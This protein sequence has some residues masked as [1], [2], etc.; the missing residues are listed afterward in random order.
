MQGE[1]FSQKELSNNEL[2]NN[3]GRFQWLSMPN[4]QRSDEGDDEGGLNLGQ[5]VSTLRR[6]IPV[7]LGVTTVVT[8]A[9][10]LKAMTSTPTYQSSF[11]I[12]TKPVTIESQVISS[13]PQTL[14]NKEQQQAGSEKG[15]DPTKL[16]LLQ[17]P[18]LLSPIVKQLQEK[19]PEITYDDIAGDLKITAPPTSEILS[20]TFQDKNAEKVKDVLKLTQDSYINYS[21][22]ERLA[23]VNQGIEFVNAQLPLLQERV[24]KIQDKLQTF[25]QEFNLID[26]E[27]TSKELSGQTTTV[28]Q[29]RLDTEIKLNEA[30][31]LY[32]DL[33][34]QLAELPNESAAASAIRDNARYQTLLNQLLE[35]KSQIAKESTVFRDGTADIQVLRD[36]KS[37]L[38]LLLRDEGQRVQQELASKI[39]E[40]DARN[41]ILVQ[42][43]AQLNQKVKQLSVVSRR[44]TDIQ[45][46]LKIATDNLNQFLTKR[47][48]L[49]I[50][51]GQRKAPWQIVTPPTDPIPSNANVKRSGLMGA[52]LGL[53]LGV[54]VA[55]FLDKLSNV[56][57]TSDEVKDAT[58]LPILGV[59]PFNPDLGEIEREVSE[60]TSTSIA[61]M[62]AMVQQVGQKFGL[63]HAKHSNYAA[64][65]FLEAFRSLY[66]NIRLL[67]GSD[68]PIRSFAISSSTPGEGKSTVSVNL[69]LAAAA[70]GQRV[71]LVDTDL[72]LPQLHN[73]LGLMNSYGLSNAISSDLDLEKLIQQSQ[74]ESNLFVLTAGHVPPDPTKLLSSQK[75]KDLMTQFQE[76]YDLVIYD[77]PPLLR[78][79]D[80]KLIAAKTDGIVMVVGL[81]KIKS[82]VLSQALEEIKQFQ[83]SVLGIVANGSKDYAANSY[84]SYQRYYS[85]DFQELSDDQVADDQVVDPIVKPSKN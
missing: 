17:S 55:L 10:L 73:R 13:V 83:V 81:G 7:I 35:V 62:L 56:I 57:Y 28:A 8:A 29:Q 69:A 80:T 15:L 77:T 75:M 44:Y 26:P 72:R 4:Q 21:L 58:K 12:L 30:R 76:S 33:N 32:L 63:N 20:V 66:A 85:S 65:P 45:Q 22:E 27:S 39:R 78:L 2:S 14:S 9:A 23:D 42:A 1:Q 18:K 47:E 38:L 37:N 51:A 25:R 24:E 3:N 43:E 67:F 53:L 48:A 41:Q 68:T 34:K 84:D 70:L 16:K 6:R 52:I 11:E 46:E 5:V 59:I 40:L 19:Y 71:L 49:R 74:I 79:A 64:S 36:Q 82:S 61:D 54:G 50:D 31:A 60:G